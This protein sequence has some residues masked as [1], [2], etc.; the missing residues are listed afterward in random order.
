MNLRLSAVSPFD[1]NLSTRIFSGSDESTGGYKSGR[2]TQVLRVG[3][4]LVLAVISSVGTI[5]EPSLLVEVLPDRRISSKGEE[6]IRSRVSL[7][8]NLNLHLAPFYEHVKG[9]KVLATFT[10][11]LRGLRSPTTTTVFEALIS[12]IIEQQIS[13][14]VALVLEDNLIKASGDKLK[15][16]KRVY[17]GFPTPKKLSSLTTGQLR[18]CGLSGKKAE[19]ARDVSRLIVDGAFDL[20]KLENLSDDKA[21]IEELDKVRGIGVWTAEMTM[22]RGM[23]RFGVIPADDLGVRRVVA[24]Y[25]KDDRMISEAEVR[26]IADRWGPW[27]GLAAF[28]LI[29]ASMLQIE[30]DQ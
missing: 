6:T 13:L 24:H 29:I 14:N 23:H 12:S 7:M 2:F 15:I 10:R 17:Y 30:V 5:D 4:R 19:Y 11:R 1:F 3:D 21:V 16:G 22:I 18:K 28:Y 25:Y 20:E 26:Q 27:K 8:F 9:D